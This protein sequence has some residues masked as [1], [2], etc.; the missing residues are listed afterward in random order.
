MISYHVAVS[1]HPRLLA[2]TATFK[3]QLWQV[4]TLWMWLV[5]SMLDL[6]LHKDKWFPGKR[7]IKMTQAGWRLVWLFLLELSYED[8][9]RQTCSRTC[10]PWSSVHLLYCVYLS[11]GKRLALQQITNAAGG[12]ASAVAAMQYCSCHQERSPD[13]QSGIHRM[14]FA[15]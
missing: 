9:Q 7:G 14:H 8:K 1:I 2:I 15:L 10:L 11:K 13:I 12:A 6:R 4:S 5:S 3:K